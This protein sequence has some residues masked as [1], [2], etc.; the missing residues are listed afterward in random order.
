AGGRGAHGRG[1]SGH[2][3]RSGQHQVV[4]T[5]A[6]VVGTE[7]VGGAEV[8]GSVG[9]AL[10]QAGEVVANG[11]AA[12]VV[13]DGQ[14]V[15][16]GGRE[17]QSQAQ[18]QAGGREAIACQGDAAGRLNHLDAAGAGSQADGAAVAVQGRGSAR[19]FIQHDL[20]WTANALDD[21]GGSSWC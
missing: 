19:A 4:A 8:A 17:G 18:G 20:T 16:R 7:R 13:D 6:A 11:T 9:S 12:G 2:G 15:S 3:R 1:G 10:G 21:G 14:L 5:A